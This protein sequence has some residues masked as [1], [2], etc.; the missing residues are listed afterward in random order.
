MSVNGDFILSINGKALC[1]LISSNSSSVGGISG[2][3]NT[4]QSMV[5]SDKNAP[6]KKE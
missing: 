2:V 5:A 3:L 6:I 1:L 4:D